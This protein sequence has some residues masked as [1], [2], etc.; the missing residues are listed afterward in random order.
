MCADILAAAYGQIVQLAFTSCFIKMESEARLSHFNNVA[1]FQHAWSM[2]DQIYS[3][4]LLLT[5]LA[6][7]GE[8]VDAFMEATKA[9][10]VLRNRMDHLDARIPNIAASKGQFRSLFGSLSYFV[11]GAAIGSPEVDAYL[12]SQQAEPARPNEVLGLLN[13]P[14]DLR[15]PIGNFVLSAA[16]EMLDLDAT[17]LTLGPVMTHTNNGFEKNIRAQVAEKA[18]EHGVE[19]SALLAHLG[20]AYRFMLPLKA[21]PD[22]GQYTM[23]PMGPETSGGIS[24]LVPH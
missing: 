2:V 18:I 3:L 15:M 20:A 11:Q 10:Y 6:F 13:L 22:A 5:S 1:M 12:V 8:D 4:R 23:G 24:R 17:I 14:A 16:G 7:T 21:G 9:A 19:E